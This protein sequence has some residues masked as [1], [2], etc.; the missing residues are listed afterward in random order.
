MVAEDG[1][2]GG[3][4]H[5]VAEAHQDRGREQSEVVRGR[6]REHG[7]GAE[8]DEPDAQH[9]GGTDAVDQKARRGLAQ[10]RGQEQRAQHEAELGVADVEG[11]AQNREQ[12]RQD[13]V[14]IVAAAMRRAD[15]GDHPD[16]AP[17]RR[18]RG[19]HRRQP[20]FTAVPL[21]ATMSMLPSLPM[22][23]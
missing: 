2:V 13:E 7:S 12:G 3:V 9:P 4:E 15:D 1:V 5:A 14:E 11:G 20:S 23:S 22:T 10:A 19:R 21:A 8:A 17:Q 16:I 18:C 6:G